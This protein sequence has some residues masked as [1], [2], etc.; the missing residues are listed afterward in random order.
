MAPEVFLGCMYSG[1]KVDSWS[2]GI[3]IT[4]LL[5]NHK[6]WPGIKLSQC[7]RKVLSL[8]HSDVSVFER[9]MR[10][11]NCYNIYEVLKKTENFSP[12]I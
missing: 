12:Q 8:I 7:L 1:V 11:H 9:I 10:E 5:I 2:L 3:I 4:E 6:L